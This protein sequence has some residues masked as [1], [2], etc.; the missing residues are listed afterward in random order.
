MNSR[1]RLVAMARGGDVDRAP[2]FAW[3]GGASAKQA[4]DFAKSFSPDAIVVSSAIRAEQALQ[5][6]DENGP[7]V[8]VE[9]GNPFG[10]ALQ[11]GVDLNEEFA[12]GPES[13][14]EAFSAFVEGVGSSLHAALES[15]AD[16]VLYR[17]FGAEPSLS[18]PMQ[19]GGHYLE[20][21]RELLQSISDARFNVVYIE[22]GD[23]VFL[24][25]VS[26]LPA[27]AL[28]WDEQRSHI[29]PSEVRK[30]REGALACG[31]FSDVRKLWEEFGGKGL[32][33]SGRVDDLSE[34][35]FKE[36]IDVVQLLRS[37]AAHE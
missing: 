29:P 16:G 23:E 36:I 10:E 30:M 31:L 19:F 26:D 13:G 21:E 14:D 22:G 18:T 20:R 25:V 34:F 28:G 5:E 32:I 2:W 6:L 17:V 12:K 7:A 15:G 1:E 27:H 11:S 9:V 4:L 37:P 3:S 35:D 33:I 24:D 8:L